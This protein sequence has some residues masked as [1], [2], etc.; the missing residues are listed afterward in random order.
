[1]GLTANAKVFNFVLT[2]E[3]P[4]STLQAVR[5]IDSSINRAGGLQDSPA[6]FFC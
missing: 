3:Y 2:R 1:M 4:G 6:L 5:D